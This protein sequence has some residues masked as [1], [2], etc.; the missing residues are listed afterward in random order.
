MK[1]DSD[2]YRKFM[3]EL[4]PPREVDMTE[5]EKFEELWAKENS[6]QGP[7]LS[8][9]KG[10]CFF[11]YKAGIQKMREEMDALKRDKIFLMGK[12]NDEH[13]K[14]TQLEG[15][16]ARIHSMR[17]KVALVEISDN[18]AEAMDNER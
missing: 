10:E 5:E 11:Y 16:L 13:K 7:I 15:E 18:E 17:E 9:R 8:G 3:K 2:E 6:W 4:G 1:R 12:Y 14:V